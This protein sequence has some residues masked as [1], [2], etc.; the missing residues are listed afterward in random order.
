MCNNVS[1][2]L[3]NPKRYYQDEYLS[4]HNN[5]ESL[6]QRVVSVGLESLLRN[7]YI[8]TKKNAL[9]FCISMLG[10][11]IV[12]QWPSGNA[13]AS[14][15]RSNRCHKAY[16]HSPTL[17]KPCIMGAMDPH[18]DNTNISLAMEAGKYK[19]SKLHIFLNLYQHLTLTVKE[20]IF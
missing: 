7:E 20:K 9:L 4:G 1:L 11:Y 6:G 10:V 19:T 13:V 5:K 12:G 2:Y 3:V 17:G 15:S 16:T 14:Q 8:T 18:I